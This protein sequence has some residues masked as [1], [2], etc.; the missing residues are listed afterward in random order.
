MCT[1]VKNRVQTCATLFSHMSLNEKYVLNMFGIKTIEQMLGA[2]SFTCF[3]PSALL[4][5]VLFSYA[6]FFFLFSTENRSFTFWFTKVGLC[7]QVTHIFLQETCFQ[8]AQNNKFLKADTQH[9]SHL[10]DFF[11]RMCFTTFLNPT[12]DPNRGPWVP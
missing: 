2:Q 5:L 1:I 7:F 4:F 11:I 9:V 10:K 8:T 6:S 3:F 12:G